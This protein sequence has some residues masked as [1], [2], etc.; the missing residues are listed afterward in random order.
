VESPSEEA[1]S[2]DIPLGITLNG[3][4]G[5]RKAATMPM[6]LARRRKVVAINDSK[7]DLI[8][9]ARYEGL[10]RKALICLK[11]HLSVSKPKDLE[12]PSDRENT[13]LGRRP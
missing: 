5:K 11:K 2:G 3:E 1:G 10:A 8:V 6:S 7:G 13:E 9:Q 12:S 4:L